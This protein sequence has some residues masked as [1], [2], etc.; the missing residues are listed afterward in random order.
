MT[1]Q[2]KAWQ[3]TLSPYLSDYGPRVR[4]GGK[5][6]HP[7]RPPQ[8][9]SSKAKPALEGSDLGNL[10]DHHPT[11]HQED[12]KIGPNTVEDSNRPLRTD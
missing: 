2:D 3:G 5:A 7:Y 8:R 1:G 4:V 12:S 11:H 10:L 9:F 6:A